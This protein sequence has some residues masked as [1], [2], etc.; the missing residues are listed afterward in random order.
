MYGVSK[1]IKFCYILSL[2]SSVYQLDPTVQFALP[3]TLLCENNQFC[4]CYLS[5]N[6]P[7]NFFDLTTQPILQNEL[8]QRY[9]A[10]S[11]T[12]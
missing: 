8:N 11:P 3:R 6:I 4:K 5:S 10:Y 1:S 9:V 7:N 12:A 2:W